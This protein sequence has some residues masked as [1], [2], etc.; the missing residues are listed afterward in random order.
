MILKTRGKSYILVKC[1]NPVIG[2]MFKDWKR[3]DAMLFKFPFRS[4]WGGLWMPFCPR[5][6]VIF[7]DNMKVVDKKSA[8]PLTLDPRTWRLYSSSKPYDSLIE[9]KPEN[10][11]KAGDKIVIE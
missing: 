6:D 10:D 2:M 4:K 3:F 11:I 5:M 9:I 7:L 1:K 8:V